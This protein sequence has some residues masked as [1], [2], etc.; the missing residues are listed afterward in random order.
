MKTS[1]QNLSPV[2]E[3]IKV[4]WD[5]GIKSIRQM[6]RDHEVS[7]T[8]IHK[9][10][11]QHKWAK[12]PKRAK[13][14]PDKSAHEMIVVN[15]ISADRAGASRSKAEEQASEAIRKA[16]RSDPKDMVEDTL[17]VLARLRDELD[18][19]TL[20]VGEL[21]DM[22][23]DY[24]KDDRDGRRRNAMLKAVSLPVRILAAKNLSLALRTLQEAAPGKKEKA[25]R[26][27]D[28]AGR[29]TAWGDD[30]EAGFVN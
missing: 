14:D 25:Q 29:G 5:N 12:R 22:I 28:A 6:A 23:L 2:E 8:W 9:L 1:E 21:E 15:A 30:L 3:A 17:D 11:K 27:A 16:A 4:D 20:H 18:T 26:D 10:A 19:A 7:D 13:I 24:T